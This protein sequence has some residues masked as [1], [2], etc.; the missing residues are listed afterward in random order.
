[1]EKIYSKIEPGCL[2]HLIY[3]L[4]DF[5]EERENLIES[6]QFIQCASLCMQKGK[7]FKPHRHIIKES[8]DE[9]RIAQ[10]SWVIIR[11]L[12]KC[13]FYDLDN[14]IIVEP[15]LKAGD[16]SFTLYGGHTYTVLTDNTLVYEFKTGPYKN[17]KLDKVFLDEL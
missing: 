7:T 17:Q 9:A 11:G 15:I 10:E 2:L 14:T 8:H 6:D 12:V 3:R 4:S 5:P 1:M 16:A 13:T